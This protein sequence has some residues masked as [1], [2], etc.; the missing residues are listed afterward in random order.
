MLKCYATLHTIKAGLATVA[1]AV[2]WLLDAASLSHVDKY[3]VQ[4]FWA[5][6]SHAG[7]AVNSSATDKT[8]PVKS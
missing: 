3:S 6:R 8:E 1:Y 7:A 5:I 4:S 2:T